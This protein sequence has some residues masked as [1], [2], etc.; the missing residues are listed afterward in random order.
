MASRSK[1][2]GLDAVTP[3]MVL[4]DDLLDS[5]GQVL[6]PQ[7]ATLTEAT[8]A[9]LRRHAIDAL[10]ILCEPLSEAEVAAEQ[11]RHQQ[12]LTRLF[13]K[14]TNDEATALLLE[15]VTRFRLGA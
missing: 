7:G 12:R 9:S 10:P 14:H 6:L 11:D 4:S 8:L 5:H 1:Q 15:Y 13:R 2:L 3:G